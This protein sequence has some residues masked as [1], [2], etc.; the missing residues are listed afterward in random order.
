M[1]QRSSLAWYV[2]GA[3]IKE[4]GT[5][6]FDAIAWKRVLDDFDGLAMG[7]LPDGSPAFKDEDGVEWGFINLFS[8]ADLEHLVNQY[9]IVNYNGGDEV[10]QFCLANRTSRNFTNLQE[11]AEWRPTTNLSNEAGTKKLRV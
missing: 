3:T 7:L 11:D 2:Y 10:C 5:H 9:G 6:K 4:T 8:G 1:T